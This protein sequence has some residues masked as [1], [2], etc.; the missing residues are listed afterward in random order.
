MAYGRATSAILLALLATLAL[1]VNSP[2]SLMNS[3]PPSKLS[4][5][6]ALSDTLIK[7]NYDKLCYPMPMSNVAWAADVGTLLMVI[8]DANGYLHGL[9]LNSSSLPTVLWSRKIGD[10]RIR[11][12][13]AEDIDRDGHAEIITVC[14]NG[15]IF[16]INWDTGSVEWEWCQDEYEDPAWSSRIYFEDVDSDGKLEVVLAVVFWTSVY[17]HYAVYTL[18]LDEDGTERI[19]IL[20]RGDQ[21]E[22]WPDNIGMGDLNGDGIRDLVLMFGASRYPDEQPRIV[23]Y[24]IT[25]DEPEVLLNFTHTYTVS[26]MSRLR[27][28]DVDDDDVPEFVCS[29]WSCPVAVFDDDGSLIW[30]RNILG[31]TADRNVLFVKDLD[32][33]GTK[34]VIAGTAAYGIESELYLYALN[35]TNGEYLWDSPVAFDNCRG[36]YGCVSGQLDTDPGS[37]IVVEI[38]HNDRQQVRLACV[39]GADGATDWIIGYSW[40]V[41]GCW[42]AGLSQGGACR[43]RSAIELADVDGDGDLEI[44]TGKGD[45]LVCINGDGSL[46]WALNMSLSIDEGRWLSLYVFHVP[47][48][49]VSP[50]FGTSDTLITAYG[51]GFTPCSRV[52][53]YA[54]EELVAMCR[55]DENGSFITYFTLQGSPGCYVIKAVDENGLAATAIFDLY[56]YTP[57][58]VDIDVGSVHF[59]GEIA[60]FFVLITHHGRPVNITSLNATIYWPNSTVQTLTYEQIATGLYK[61]T[62]DIPVDAPTGTYT[63][64]VIAQ[65]KT[66]HIDAWGSAIR[67]FLLSPTLTEWNAMLIAIENDTAIIKTDVGVIRMNLAE[68]D[69]EIEGIQGDLIVVKTDVGTILAKLDVLNATLTGLIQNAKGEVIAQIQTVLGNL[70]TR[71]DALNATIISLKGDIAVINTTLGQ[72]EA[73]LDIL[74]TTITLIE[75]NVV[76][77]KTILGRIEG[78]IADINGH[79]VTIETDMGWIK[80]RIAEWTGTTTSVAGFKVMALTTSELKALWAEETVVKISLYAPSDGHLHIF[81]PKSLLTYLGVS[82]STVDIMI[83]WTKLSY[84]VVDLGASYMLLVR[85]GPGDHMI[86]VYLN[87]APIYRTAHGI[88]LIGGGAAATLGVIIWLIRRK[89]KE[90]LL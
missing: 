87:G 24:D 28:A 50:S 23:V 54:N 37:E 41:N 77:V 66:G 86:E 58:D 16:C 17:A 84:D 51:E 43:G 59:R 35:A 61:T 33:D 10:E 9:M 38:G 4:Q 26:G 63:L 76:E 53:I 40:T 46:V 19:S 83:G 8:G 11:Q 75:G 32:G 80:A 22:E 81:I 1:M 85:Y 47:M 34:A 13:A 36:V 44:I 68:I 12:V 60:E 18:C 5:A 65:L 2:L 27:V 89:R 7:F 69:A 70:T 78:T 62:F 14:E 25:G 15:T 79:L 52:S 49:Y 56:D 74:N 30:D 71:L 39:D 55:T 45:Y 73:G 21:G 67:S 3:N 6:Q 82:L 29:G 48:L 72:I 90:A 88:A 57:L 64:F 20:Y 42:P 31:G